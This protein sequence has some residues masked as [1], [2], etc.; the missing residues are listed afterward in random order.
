MINKNIKRTRRATKVR[1]KIRQQDGFRLCVHKTSQHIYAQVISPNGSEILVTAS[2]L[3]KEL[4]EEFS[5]GGN[6]EAAIK[7]GKLVAQRCLAKG[8]KKLAF[9]RSGFKYHGRVQELANAAREVGL[10][11]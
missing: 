7:V 9:D 8:I 1:A 4:R 3:D 11:F 2:S 6:K 5:N 10:E